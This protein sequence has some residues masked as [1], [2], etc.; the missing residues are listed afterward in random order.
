[1]V[2][3]GKALLLLLGAAGL[4]LAL[5]HNTI[6][7]EVTASI[8]NVPSVLTDGGDV[9]VTAGD[10]RGSSSTQGRARAAG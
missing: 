2:I 7:K 4:G 6:D 9:T 1:M 8:V 10:P 3:A 5:A